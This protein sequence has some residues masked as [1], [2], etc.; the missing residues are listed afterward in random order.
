MGFS[1]AHLIY[2]PAALSAVAYATVLA[3]NNLN[4]SWSIAYLV[5]INL[6]AFAFFAFDKLFARLLA[7]LRLR[8]PE[9]VLIWQLAFPGGIA[10]A[11][12]AMYALQHKTGPDSSAFRSNLVK[13]YAVLI[14]LFL[15]TRKWPI[16]SQQQMDTL[17]ASL[18]STVLNVVHILLTTARAS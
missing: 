2:G 4:L 10:G 6:A 11:T 15:I 13:A 16:V 14:T 12:A 7:A 17:V 18:T 3:H 9:D 8:V 1:I 5:A